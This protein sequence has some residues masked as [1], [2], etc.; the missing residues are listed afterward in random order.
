MENR[1]IKGMLLLE[2]VFKLEE[3]ERAPWVPFV[4]VHGAGIIGVDAET[5]L[6]SSK[7]IVNGVSK[8]IDLY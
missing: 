3:T 6:K 1:E 7:H 4:G 8:A 5:C 2:S